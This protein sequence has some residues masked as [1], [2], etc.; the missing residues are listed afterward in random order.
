MSPEELKQLRGGQQGCTYGTT[1][2]LVDAVYAA[3]AE[4]KGLRGAEAA[5]DE[6]GEYLHELVEQLKKSMYD[7]V[8]EFRTSRLIRAEFRKIMQKH[9]LQSMTFKEDES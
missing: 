3:Q 6:F 8:E 4:V 2:R 9:A 5:L 1:K 7:N